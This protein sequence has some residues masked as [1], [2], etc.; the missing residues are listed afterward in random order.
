MSAGFH[1]TVKIIPGGRVSSWLAAQPIGSLI[2]ITKTLTKRLAAP[3]SSSGA[4]GRHLGLICYGI[5]VTE[6]I[7][8]AK[9]ALEAGQAVK[10]VYAIRA[11]ADMLFVK[12]LCAL[13]AAYPTAA[14][15]HGLDAGQN[16]GRFELHLLL[17]REEPS[18]AFT[19]SLRETVGDSEV[20]PGNGAVVVVGNFE[21]SAPAVPST[22]TLAAA[23]SVDRHEPSVVKSYGTN[24]PSL[25]PAGIAS[26]VHVRRGRVD[27]AQ[28]D[29]IFTADASESRLWRNDNISAFMVVGSKIQ[30]RS[31]YALL[32]KLGM[33][34]QLLGRPVLWGCW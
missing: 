28:L 1:I 16:R 12:E 6:C 26:N 13:A 3:L 18:P 5:G 30:K 33:K 24:E 15:N 11:A 25:K 17:S 27:E 4:A 34:K 29:S 19:S 10:L 23:E 21:N 32:R 31:T 20:E 14:G 2:P 9:W 22:M 8:T 7:L